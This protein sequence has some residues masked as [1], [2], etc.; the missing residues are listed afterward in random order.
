MLNKSKGN[1][2]IWILVLALLGGMLGGFMVNAIRL[3]AANPTSMTL[4]SYL[5]ADIVALVA[6]LWLVRSARKAR[7]RARQEEEELSYM[8][9][10]M[11]QEIEEDLSLYDEKDYH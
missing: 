10:E 4:W 8:Q 7:R 1:D 11:Q 3:I 2:R 9:E 6:V 5:I